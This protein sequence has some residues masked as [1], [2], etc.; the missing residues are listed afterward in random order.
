M[1]EWIIGKEDDGRRIE[2]WLQGSAPGL[3]A[4]LMQKFLRQK[5]IKVNQQAARQGARLRAGDVVRAYI[6][7]TYFEERPRENRLLARF[8]HA[9]SIVYEDENLLIV[10]KKPGLRVHFDAEEK[11][12]T[13]LTH[14]RAYLYQKGEYDGFDSVPALCN[15]IDRFTGGIVIAAKNREVLLMMDQKIRAREVRRYYL[16]AAAGRM[17]RESGA[18]KGY[19]VKSG[20]RVTVRAQSVPGAQYAETLYRVLSYDGAVSLVECELITGRTHQIR[21]QFAAAGRPLIGDSQ[22]GDDAINRQYGARF[23][24]LYAHRVAFEFKTE[25]GVLQYLNG[26]SLRVNALHRGFAEIERRGADG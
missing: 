26:R 6:E 3:G 16:C 19:I 5:K 8:R 15:R 7:D 12:D 1:R 4:G 13:L 17:P 10:D 14:I 23:Q 25:A 11:V 18:L 22:Y 2:K 20:K 24:Q 21:A 9:L